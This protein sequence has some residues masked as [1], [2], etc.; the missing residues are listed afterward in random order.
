VKGN[1]ERRTM[2]DESLPVLQTSSPLS[3]IHRSLFINHQ[4]SFIDPDATG[5]RGAGRF[6]T[7][8][9]EYAR[10]GGRATLKE[11]EIRVHSWPL[12][13]LHHKIR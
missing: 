7:N 2:K 13:L 6:A 4:S 1:D 10:I 12:F 8:E 11:P 3:F 9:H 5:F